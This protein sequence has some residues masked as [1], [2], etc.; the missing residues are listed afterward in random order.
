MTSEAIKTSLRL[1]SLAT[2]ALGALATAHAQ[3]GTPVAVNLTAQRSSLTLPDQKVVPMW[4]FCGS[5]AP[6][7]AS[8]CSGSWAPG[9]TIV[10]P[11]GGELDITL[12]NNL[13]TPTSIVILGQLGGG[14][15]STTAGGGVGHP[16]TV[17]SPPHAPKNT[18]T[19]PSSTNSTFT[20]PLQ[21]ARMQSFGTETAIGGQLTYRWAGLKAGTYLYE[22]GTNP[23]IQV[24]MGLYGVLVV[25][26]VPTTL[27]T[28]TPSLV[29]GQ[30]YPNAFAQTNSLTSEFTNVP[31]DADAVML[32][33][34][35]DAAQNTAVDGLCPPS[36]APCTSID[37]LTYPAAVNYAPTYFLI[38]GK[39]FDRTNPTGIHGARRCLHRQSS[40][41]L[42]QRRIANPRSLRGRTEHAS[43]R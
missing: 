5:V 38:N 33:S 4:Q 9:P 10:V 23:S 37:P 14:S 25:T 29:P 28:A 19:W 32:L 20:P 30:A 31:Y 22:T 35:I 27:T 18:T 42:R 13:P 2:L 21:G 41:A 40:P 3:T 43:H 16:T 7:T 1:I 6:A 8:T 36:P 17:Q 11:V 12:T 34:E 26:N 39:P 15:S 24:P